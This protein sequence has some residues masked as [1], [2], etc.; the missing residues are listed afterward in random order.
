MPVK[1]RPFVKRKPTFFVSAGVFP[2]GIAAIHEGIMGPA[3]APLDKIPVVEALR[4]VKHKTLSFTWSQWSQGHF[5]NREDWNEWL[6]V[7][8]NPNV[9]LG[10]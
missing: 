1:V 5:L 10:T 7:F 6:I 4:H 2:V 9:L 3:Y 8:L